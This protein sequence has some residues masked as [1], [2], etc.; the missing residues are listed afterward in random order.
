M[1]CTPLY[2]IGRW[3]FRRAVCNR[4]YDL[5]IDVRKCNFCRQVIGTVNAHKSG[6]VTFTIMPCEQLT[7]D[8]IVYSWIKVEIETT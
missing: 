8:R 3:K 5:G 4:P 6:L 1:Q 2:D 7:V